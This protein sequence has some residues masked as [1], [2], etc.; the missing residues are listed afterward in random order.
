MAREIGRTKNPLGR[1]EGTEHAGQ[2]GR[3]RA[4]ACTAPAKGMME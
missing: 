4:A 1:N 2:C 3:I